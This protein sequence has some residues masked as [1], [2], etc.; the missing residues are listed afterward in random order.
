MSSEARRSTSRDRSALANE[1]PVTSWPQVYTSTSLESASCVGEPSTSP[2]PPSKAMSLSS[3]RPQMGQRL[4]RGSRP[5]S[6]GGAMFSSFPRRVVVKPPWYRPLASV[7]STRPLPASAGAVGAGASPTWTSKGGRSV[8]AR[9]SNGSA[10]SPS[11]P[12]G[13]ACGSRP[14]RWVTS[15]RRAWTPRAGSSTCTTT[16]GVGGEIGRSSTRCT[17]SR[18]RF[19]GSAAG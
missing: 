11:L 18:G 14:I 19:R 7:G 1:A 15:R 16:G 3:P 9:L 12:P 6:S 10:R 5:R 13:R 17:T 2:V 8:T 4:V